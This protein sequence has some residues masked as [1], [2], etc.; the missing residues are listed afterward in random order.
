MKNLKLIIL[1]L[2]IFNFSSHLNAEIKI[3]Y[4]IDEYIITNIDILN[5]INYLIF[6][7][8]NLSTIPE[9]EQMKISENSIVRGIIKKKRIRQSIR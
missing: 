8:P 4:K 9:I 3:K 5:E 6:L 1:L 7:R 2:I